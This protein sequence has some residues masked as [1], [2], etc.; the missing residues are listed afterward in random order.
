MKILDLCFD[1]GLFSANCKIEKINWEMLE[2]RRFFLRLPKFWL[3][4]FLLFLIQILIFVSILFFEFRFIIR[5]S[6]VRCRIKRLAQLT[7]SVKQ[8]TLEENVPE[9]HFR[10][11]SAGSRISFGTLNCRLQGTNA[12][13]F[14][15]AS[16]LISFH[17]ISSIQEVTRF[18]RRRRTWKWNW[19]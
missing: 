13:T 10:A 6:L 5:M 2:K 14:N 8:V 3:L 9:T 18:P 11:R 7:S 15:P 16:G 12:S 1:S 19:Q 4:C 17:Q